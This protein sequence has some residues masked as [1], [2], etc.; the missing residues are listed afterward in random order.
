MGSGKSGLPVELHAEMS[1]SVITAT[2]NTGCLNFIVFTI[3]CTR[4]A[5]NVKA[6]LTCYPEL[7]CEKQW[8]YE[9]FMKNS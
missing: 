4:F 7:T 2:S 5:F 8:K 6:L 9:E 1:S 3:S